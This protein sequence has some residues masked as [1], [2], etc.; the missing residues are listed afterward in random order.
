MITEA[1][2]AK[3]KVILL[4]RTP[5]LREDILNP[6]SKLEQNSQQIR[7]LATTYKVGLADS[8]AI[9]KEIAK[10]DSLTPF[11]AQINHI[12]EKGHQLV[13]KAIMDYF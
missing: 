9:F 1:L 7:A 11:M 4:T 10:K 2:A 3:V 12:N 8:N 6:N 13:A 5:D